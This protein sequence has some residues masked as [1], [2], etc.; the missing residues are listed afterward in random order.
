[1]YIKMVSSYSLVQEFA[2]IKLISLN[3]NERLG[4]I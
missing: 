1:M 4:I 2:G 3:D